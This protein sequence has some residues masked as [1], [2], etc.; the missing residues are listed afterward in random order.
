MSANAAK[1]HANN[2][3]GTSKV[4]DKLNFIARAIYELASS[5]SDIEDD[6]K[7]IKNSQR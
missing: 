2:A 6:V 3:T 5:I 1:A 4:E 7:R